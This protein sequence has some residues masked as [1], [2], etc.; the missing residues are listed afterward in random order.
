MR[1]SILDLDKSIGLS[2]PRQ[3]FA[4]QQFV[5]IYVRSPRNK[6]PKAV[7]VQF[8]YKDGSIYIENII[9]D[10]KEIEKKFKFLRKAKRSG[11]LIDRQHYFV[12]ES[13]EKYISC[14]TSDKFTPKLIG[15]DG[16]LEEMEE[17]TLEINRGTSKL[18]PLV[19]YYNDE[20]KPKNKIQKMICLDLKNDDFIQYYVPSAQ[21]IPQSIPRAFRVYHFIGRPYE[22]EDRIPTSELIKEPIAALHFSTLTHDVLKISENSQS[23]LLQKIARVLI[24]N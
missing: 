8:L 9:R 12:D 3:S 1:Q 7:A 24:E 20:I 21:N 5:T 22:S 10:L 4:E 18:L 11:K 6:K 23:S 15:R 17:G 2:I 13:A 14:Y 16:I 19:S